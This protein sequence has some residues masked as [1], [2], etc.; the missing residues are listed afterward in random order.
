ML[1]FSKGVPR[2]RRAHN[3]SDYAASVSMNG[4]ESRG[5][6]ISGTLT[7]ESVVRMNNDGWQPV[8][9]GLIYTCR[10]CPTA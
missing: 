2:L 9:R 1:M 6:R 10:L 3:G 4:C 5:C 8:T 7:S